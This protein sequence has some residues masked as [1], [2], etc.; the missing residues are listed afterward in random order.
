[1][2]GGRRV[3]WSVAGPRDGTPVV[4]LHGGIGT[5]IQRAPKLDEVIH[6]LHIR[7]VTISRP[8]FGGS[9]HQPGRRI[10]D[11]P[12]DLERVA[13]HLGLDVLAVVGISSGGPY[14]LA[15]ALHMPDRIAATGV[16][17]CPS[18]STAPHE[19]R[20]MPAHVRLGLRTVIE[21]PALVER[22]AER[23]IGF[24]ERHQRSVTKL[25]LLGASNADRSTLATAKL[26]E[27][28]MGSFLGAASGGVRGMLQDYALCCA[29][30]GFDV[31]DIH[32]EVHL[33]HGADDDFVPLEHARALAAALPRCRATI[34][35]D[36][37]HFFYRRRMA[38]VLE[39]LVS[40]VRH[41][42]RPKANTLRVAA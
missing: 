32:S 40:A 23:L 24:L 26:R 7:H 17:S 33:W 2:P 13:D 38:D 25:A 8:G 36:D 20:A 29:P 15:S 16:V 5:P 1:M 28:A 42:E 18:P 27:S 35:T 31:G 4:Y 41:T 34:G 11:F 6:R 37:G 39:T 21:R 19:C 30:W 9:D 14:A 10:A 3:A 12:H 22:A